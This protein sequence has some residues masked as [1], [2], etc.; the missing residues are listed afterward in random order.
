[1]VGDFAHRTSADRGD[2]RNRQQIGHER[3]RAFGVRARERREYALIFRPG[4]GRA[5][6]EPIEILRQRCLVIEILDQPPLPRGRQIE[7]RDK[8]AKQGDIAH[9]DAGRGKP[10][11]RRRLNPKRQHFAIYRRDILATERFNACLQEFPA[12]VPAMTKH[13]AEIAKATRLAGFG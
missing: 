5:D 2:A 3:V 9:S 7:R 8:G 12:A 13:R 1:M 4:I 6:G 10:V 11:M